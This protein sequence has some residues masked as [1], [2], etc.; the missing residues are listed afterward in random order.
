MFWHSRSGNAD[1]NI[2]LLDDAGQL[3]Y[4]DFFETA[5]SLFLTLSRG[6]VAIICNKDRETVIGYVGALRSGLV[7][8]LLDSTAEE[9][10]LLNLIDRY[11]TEY[12]WA[13]Q[14]ITPDGYE[15][16]RRFNNQILWKRHLP[17]SVGEISPTL[18]ALIPTSGSTGRPKSC[19]PQS[20]KN[21]TSVTSCIADY[22]K[23]DETPSRHFASSSSIL[24]RHVRTQLY[25]GG[26]RLLR[27]H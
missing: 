1:N 19:S 2:F 5:D 24:L 25:Y 14:G 4:R 16:L 27:D 8:L 6:V 10:S 17:S 7:P 9:A 18:F 12:L 20:A 23:L 26:A 11:A 13:R 15:E 22:L 21:L 3:T